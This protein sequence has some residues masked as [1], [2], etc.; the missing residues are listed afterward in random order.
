VDHKVGRR[1][2]GEGPFSV[3]GGRRRGNESSFQ[4]HVKWKE[5]MRK[6]FSSLL[7]R[8]RGDEKVF[9]MDRKEGSVI[10]QG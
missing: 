8:R 5:M 3:P 10:V 9:D 6:S 7:G 4:D 1:G 2:D